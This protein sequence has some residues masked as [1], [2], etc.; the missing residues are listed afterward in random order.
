VATQKDKD[1][2]AS[3][4]GEEPQVEL[5]HAGPLVPVLQGDGV[6]QVDEKVNPAQDELQSTS[7]RPSAKGYL[8][9]EAIPRPTE[10]YSVEGVTAVKPT[11]ESERGSI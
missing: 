9:V 2:G 1:K 6:G 8:G 7:T 10:H 5:E 4:Q 3:P 11:P